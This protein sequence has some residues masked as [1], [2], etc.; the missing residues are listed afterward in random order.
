MSQEEFACWVEKRGTEPHRYELLNGRVVMTPPAGYPHGEIEATLVALLRQHV[1][2][3]KLGKVFGSRQGFDLPSGDTV[4]SDASF[5]SNERWASAP[6]PE[7]GK[8]LEVV[9]DLMVEILSTSTASRD[10]GEKKAIYAQ[11]GVREYWLVDP[12]AC[13]VLVLT[14]EGARYGEPMIFAVQARVESRAL[15]GLEIEVGEIFP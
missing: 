3:G 7:P 8:F 11:N 15:P 9:P 4:A 14:L 12:R 10:R 13:E 1:A 2:A 6:P 5:V